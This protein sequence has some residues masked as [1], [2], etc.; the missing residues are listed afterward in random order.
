MVFCLCVDNFGIK[1]FN[2][3]DLNHLISTLSKYYKISTDYSGTNYCGLTMEWNYSAGYVDVSMPGYV[4]KV[5]TKFQHKIPP[6]PQHLPH[7]WH[8]PQFGTRIQLTSTPDKSP[9]L[10]KK[11]TKMYNQSSAHSFTTDGQ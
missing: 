2:K 3:N 7:K 8:C 1:Y 11:G 5:L 4:Q 6:T 10:D 9:K